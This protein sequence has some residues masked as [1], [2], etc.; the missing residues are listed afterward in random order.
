MFADRFRYVHVY[1]MRSLMLPLNILS[2]TNM[3][4]FVCVWGT[5]NIYVGI[6]IQLVKHQLEDDNRMKLI[7]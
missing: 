4:G 1:I 7:I 5:C 2:F 6:Y 3:N